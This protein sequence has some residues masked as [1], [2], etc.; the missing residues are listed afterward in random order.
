[1]LGDRLQKG[2]RKEVGEEDPSHLRQKEKKKKN[3]MIKVYQM[4]CL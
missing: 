3:L 1:M 4:E 2:R